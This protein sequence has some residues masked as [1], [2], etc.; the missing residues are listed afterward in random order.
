VTREQP[1]LRRRWKAFRKRLLGFAPFIRRSRHE[2]AIARINKHVDYLRQTNEGMGL[3]FFVPPP[4]ANTAPCDIRVPFSNAPIEELCL[5]VTYAANAE[6]K[7]HVVDH[8]NALLDASVHVVLIV[9]TDLDRASM[10][11]P[12]ELAR[13][14]YGC[15]VRQNLGFDFAAWAHAYSLIDP[16]AVRSRLYLVNDSIIGPLDLAHY[17]TM[18][19]RV[20]AS[21][22]DVVGLTA[23]PDPHEHLQSFFLVFNEGLLHSP[24]FD[25][26]MHNVVNMPH[27]QNVIDCYEIWLS[28]FLQ[29]SGFTASAIFPKLSTLPPPQ[30]NDTLIS[31]R[32]LLDIGFPFVKSMVLRDPIEGEAARH[33]VPQKYQ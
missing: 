15:L 8:V 32:A 13:R 23:N 33:V 30:R 28:P 24:T 7:S 25:A 1:S 12:P 2:R 26:L 6:L 11:I 5:F 22:A 29:K 20:R 9:N 14:L 17:A 19:Q 4:L 10:Q 18:L 16:R 3:L 31:W 21:P 27:K